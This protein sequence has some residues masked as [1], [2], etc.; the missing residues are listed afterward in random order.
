MV[1]SLGKLY[2]GINEFS[3]ATILGNGSVAL[4][5][6]PH[7]LVQE[8]I[9]GASSPGRSSIRSSSAGRKGLAPIPNHN[10]DGRN[11]GFFLQQTGAALAPQEL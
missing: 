1:K 11:D 3:G 9:R 7:R 10:Q 2:G 8:C 4:I 6:D 5:L